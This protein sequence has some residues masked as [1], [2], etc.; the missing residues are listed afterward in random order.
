MF[1]RFKEVR[2]RTSES[3]N[4]SRNPYVAIKIIMVHAF[5]V[6]ACK[7]K[8]LI[9]STVWFSLNSPTIIIGFARLAVDKVSIFALA[10]EAIVQVP[11]AIFCLVATLSDS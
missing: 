1:D 7:S 4:K 3:M 5:L 11:M 8:N 10:I 9:F 6:S 2:N